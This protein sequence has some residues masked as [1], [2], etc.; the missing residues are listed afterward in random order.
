VN[1]HWFLMDVCADGGTYI[2]EFVHGDRC[3]SIESAFK[4]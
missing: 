4:L 2:K 3:I 1:K